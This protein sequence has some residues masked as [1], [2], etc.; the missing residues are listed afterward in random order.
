MATKKP[1]HVVM[2][3]K[4]YLSVGG[5]LQHVKQGTGL[6]LDAKTAKALGGKV[7]PIVEGESV[8]L[9]GDDKK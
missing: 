7:K 3:R 5:K 4:L 2:H 6:S 1:T 8:D 9:T